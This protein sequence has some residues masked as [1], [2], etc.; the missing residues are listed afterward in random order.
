MSA[1]DTAKVWEFTLLRL[2]SNLFCNIIFITVTLV[3]IALKLSQIWHF[4]TNPKAYIQKVMWTV[5]DFYETCIS[6]L[7]LLYPKG[8]VN[9]LDFYETCI[10]KLTL[11]YPKGNVNVLDF[12][13]TCI[14]TN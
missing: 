12:Y 3:L 1:F 2:I 5:L 8:N 14:S 4:K 10:S 11:L 9:V 13:E 6:K 7:T